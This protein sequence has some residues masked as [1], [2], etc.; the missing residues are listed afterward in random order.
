[1][2]G[3]RLPLLAVFLSCLPR[4]SAGQAIHQPIV[5]Q[6]EAPAKSLPVGSNMSLSIT[7]INHSDQMLSFGTCPDPYA[8]RIANLTAKK[9]FYSGDPSVGFERGIDQIL[10]CTRNIGFRIEPGETFQI[11]FPINVTLSDAGN[12]EVN[13]RWAF[14]LNL[15]PSDTDS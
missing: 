12:Y 3:L 7:V 4:T 6:I 1:M 14:Q 2:N 13:V 15:N 11:P 9:V 5:L 10:V 8:V